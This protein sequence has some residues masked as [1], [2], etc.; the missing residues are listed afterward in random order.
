MSQH[1]QCTALHKDFPYLNNVNGDPRLLGYPAILNPFATFDSASRLDMFS[2]HRTQALI[3][4]GAE[5]CD[6]FSGFEKEDSKYTFDSSR[7]DQDVEILKVIPKYHSMRGGV[8]GGNSPHLLV[9]YKGL[10]DNKIGYFT[11]DRFFKGTDG[12]GH[13]NIWHRI[14]TAL[15]EG[16]YLEKETT[17]VTSPAKKGSQYCFG[18]NANVAFMPLHQTIEDAF[19]ISQSLADKLESEE[20]KTVVINIRQDV[21]PLN[22]YGRNGEVKFLPDIGETVSDAGILCA[23]RPVSTTTC[24]ADTDPSTLTQV[25]STRDVIFTAPPG[26]EVVDIDF[27]V[28]RHCK[29]H[30]YPQVEKYQS[31]I[32]SYWKAIWDFYRLH[33]KGSYQLTPRFNTLVTTALLRLIAMGVR[34]DLP[35]TLAD[36]RSRIEFEGINNHPVEFIQ[37]IITYR[38]KRKVEVGFKLAGKH[39]NKGVVGEIK[40]DDEM[41]VDAYGV[42]ADLII[43]PSSVTARMNEG[44]HWECGINRISEFVRRQVKILYDAGNVEQAYDTLLEW[45]KDVNPNYAQLVRSV[46]PTLQHKE[47]HLTYVFD[48]FIKIHVPHFLNTLT[49]EN[50]DAWSQ[51]WNVPRSKVSYVVKEHDGSNRRTEIS[52]CYVD[53]GRMYVEVLAKIP[54]A[55]SV[56]I[57]YESHLGTPI[58]PNK[59][60]RYSCAVSRSPIRFGE[61]ENRVMNMDMS[62]VEVERML[63]LY[64][65]APVVGV[66][67]MIDALLTEERPTAIPRI[68]V[69]NEE[70]SS[71][72][73][74]TGTLHHETSILGID[75]RNT[76]TDRTPPENLEDGGDILF[77]DH[78]LVT[79]MDTSGTKRFSADDDFDIDEPLTT[80][81]KKSAAKSAKDKTSQTGE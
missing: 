10:R 65:K 24:A 80:G 72:N 5:F 6:L 20:F 44:Q 7:R 79:D 60:A 43:D 64:A 53:I 9:L 40:P 19:V 25:E 54:H 39:G 74:V 59:E 31:S 28:N 27:Y 4:K 45:Y 70:L 29:I 81:K 56:G 73:T 63:R 61:D 46:H 22:L 78:Q 23:F 2:S 13:T 33:V 58:K 34:Q 15:A 21:R 11:V 16:S 66:N 69:T 37:A 71:G 57:A 30:S 12:F 42:R 14:P 26:A 62:S 8:G 77:M 76:A 41:P 17:L 75:T 51:K 36:N 55:T 48:N 49:L 38:A 1:V 50:F 32:A 18:T 67:R 52:E 3:I 47:K 35:S 68:A